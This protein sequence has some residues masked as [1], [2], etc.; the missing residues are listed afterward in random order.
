MK[1]KR[2]FQGK[3][4]TGMAIIEEP[5]NNAKNLFLK[6]SITEIFSIAAL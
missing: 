5:S 4:N 6:K 2:K 3:R 1:S